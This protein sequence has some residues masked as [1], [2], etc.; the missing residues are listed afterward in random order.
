M[1]KI[2]ISLGAYKGDSTDAFFDSKKINKDWH[3]LLYE[4]NMDCLQILKNKYPYAEIIN[5]AV[6]DRKGMVCFY[7][8]D[9]ILDILDNYDFCILRMDVEGSEYDIV[10]KMLLHRNIK[11]INEIYIEWHRQHEKSK[12]EQL[13]LGLIKNIPFVMESYFDENGSQRILTTH[14]T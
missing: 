10:P 1:K 12:T 7:P 6:C 11:K 2:F 14:K 4:P 13:A 5:K 3:L 8:D 9:H